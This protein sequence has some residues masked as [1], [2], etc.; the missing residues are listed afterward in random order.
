MTDWL[1]QTGYVRRWQRVHRA[2]E[3]AIMSHSIA[4]VIAEAQFDEL[5]VTGSTIQNRDELVATVRAAITVL[6]GY[7]QV[8]SAA[9]VV[10]AVAAAGAS[11]AAGTPMPPPAA[12]VPPVPAPA[13]ALPLYKR[14][15]ERL[16]RE[17]LRQ[18]RRAINEFR[19]DCRLG[20]VRARNQ[21]WR[22]VTATMVVSYL[23]VALTIR[24]GAPPSA[25]M[26]AGVFFLAGAVVGLFNKLNLDSTAQTA[27]EDYGLS[28]ARLVSTPIFSGLAAVGGVLLLPLISALVSAQDVPA[29]SPP[30]DATS[31]QASLAAAQ[32]IPKLQAIFNVVDRPAGLVIAA[33]FGLSP[34]TL[35]SRLQAATDQYKTGLKSSEAPQAQI[36][37]S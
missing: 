12:P 13:A 23:L 30:A 14:I 32:V 28:T 7:A 4:R 16:A 15:D 1:Q 10:P 19:D 24:A 9:P 2:D 5:R 20:L 11:S 21:L 31:A 36:P 22:T 26:A 37:T 18:V 29:A 3:A 34:A 27:V 6:S 8:T 17:Q 33:I 35:I 25:V